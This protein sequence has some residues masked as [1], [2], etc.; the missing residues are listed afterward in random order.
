MLKNK[1]KY[2]SFALTALFLLNTK[3]F[4]TISYSVDYS[5]S[6][7]KLRIS[8][9]A[10]DKAENGR[11]TM[12]V[13]KKGKTFDE[14]VLFNDVLFLEQTKVADGKFYFDVDY[15]CD[16][17]DYC[18]RIVSE[19]T[20]E[21]LDLSLYLND[22][23]GL[24]GLYN[25]INELAKEETDVNFKSL[26]NNSRKGLNFDFTPVSEK[27]LDTEL[28]AYKTYVK[29]NPLD[30]SYEA[31][32]TQKFKTFITMELLQN[33][34]KFNL[35]SIFGE[36]YFSDDFKKAY[37]KNIN[38]VNSK[39]DFQSTLRNFKSKTISEF[40]TNAKKT[41]I[42]TVTKYADGYSTVKDAVTMFGKDVGISKIV[43]DSVF[44]TLSGESFD[45]F[46]AFVKK[47]NTPIQSGGGS[48]S[49]FGGGGG[50]A[51][52]FS[53]DKL[54]IE[55]TSGNENTQINQLPIKMSFNDIDG[56]S[57][58]GEAILA[59]ADKNIINGKGND[60]FAP[61][62]LITR[63]EFVKMIVCALNLETFKTDKKIFEDVSDEMWC[64]DYVHTAYANDLI[65]GIG[66]GLFGVGTYITRQDM[67]VML[68]NTLRSRNIEFRKN[69][70]VFSDYE[71]I[72]DY[73]KDDVDTLAG[74]GIL[75]GIGDNL[76]APLENA[77]RAEAAKVIYGML[78]ILQ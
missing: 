37:S 31:E 29:N 63:E 39:K 40:D 9:D 71:Q 55:E 45:S 30:I 23:D 32:N 19:A 11:I 76:F 16:I 69:Y 58:A 2:M 75:N 66:N 28:N 65:N 60:R 15:S 47:Y 22:Y 4:A 49:S 14:D 64:C 25:Q 41:Y 18:T 46:D 57:W 6:E 20:K 68:Y 52:S 24:A 43:S 42:L 59:L 38:T 35:D 36:L 27:T 17:G 44:Q 78:N 50:S 12:E 26:I 73:A 70:S 51:G 77:T 10:S 67:A 21:K 74:Y 8:G 61:N 54:Q 62:D 7:G 3:C 5:Y 48:S 72:S 34:E 1:R 53:D 56:V 13:L 33:E